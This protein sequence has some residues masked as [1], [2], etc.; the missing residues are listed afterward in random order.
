ME[1]TDL[2]V[3]LS[4]LSQIPFDQINFHKFNPKKLYQSEESDPYL[5][6]YFSTN[7]SDKNEKRILANMEEND[8]NSQAVLN[9]LKKRT[10]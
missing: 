10:Q 9:K 7:N 2:S 4:S 6:E 8:K 5:E 3:D 1:I